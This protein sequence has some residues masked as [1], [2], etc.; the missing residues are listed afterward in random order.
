MPPHHA[1]HG[2]PVHP[3]QYTPSQY[4]QLRRQQA[5][6]QAAAAAQRGP[7][8]SNGFAPPSSNPNVP[9]GA[10]AAPQQASQ[11]QQAP[12]NASNGSGK[13][14]PSASQQRSSYASLAGGH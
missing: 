8:S 7:P 9:M 12:S 6:Q 4:A 10:T 5:A 2:M 14:N 11:Q 1:M 13:L 3:N